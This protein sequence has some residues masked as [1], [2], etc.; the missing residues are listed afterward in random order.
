LQFAA[1]TVAASEVTEANG[2]LRFLIPDDCLLYPDDIH[3]AVQSMGL[4]PMKVSIA[5]GT[6]QAGAAPQQPKPAADGD[7]EERAF[8]HPEVKRFREAF[9]DAHVRAVRNLKE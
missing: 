3:K 4:R 8:S 1:D 9:P 6:P 5:K 2:E 7:A